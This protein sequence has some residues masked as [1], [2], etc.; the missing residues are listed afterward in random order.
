MERFRM[1]RVQRKQILEDFFPFVLIYL[2][3]EYLK[4]S[5]LITIGGYSWSR[6]SIGTCDIFNDDHK[7]WEYF[8]TLPKEIWGTFLIQ[9]NTKLF[10]IGGFHSSSCYECDLS[11]SVTKEVVWK[12][13]A[14]MSLIRAA[15]FGFYFKDSIYIFGGFN[16]PWSKED[17]NRNRLVSGEKYN[18]K[19]N[20]WTTLSS[21]LPCE[22]FFLSVAIAVI[23]TFEKNQSIYAFAHKNPKQFQ[24]EYNILLDHWNLI[25][26][27]ETDFQ[28][29]TYI[30]FT[31]PSGIYFNYPYIYTTNNRRGPEVLLYKIFDKKSPEESYCWSYRHKYYI[32]ILPNKTNVGKESDSLVL[33]S[34]GILYVIYRLF[35]KKS[36]CFIAKWKIPR[37][38][39]SCIWIDI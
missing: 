18:M 7:Q 11:L 16:C 27:S 20:Q 33:D 38:K 37:R 21:Q 10:L 32:T 3:E 1:N 35:H 19:K 9:V 23:K 25:T 34:D 39:C 15:P 4:E 13:K 17:K 8:S 14:K 36:E 24:A 6:N 28:S 12:E 31:S 22:E 2:I 29:S 26:L 30:C 5:F